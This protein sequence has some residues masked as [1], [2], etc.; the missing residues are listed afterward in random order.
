VKTTVGARALMLS[1]ALEAASELDLS[2]C[3]HIL[4]T[5]E[6]EHKAWLRTSVGATWPQLS[7]AAPPS[8]LLSTQP[9]DNWPRILAAWTALQTWRTA[10]PLW[11]AARALTH[12]ATA[13]P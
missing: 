8:R 1:R 12:P 4:P 13:H 2:S 5:A 3:C 7:R 9:A 11:A 6:W 10:P